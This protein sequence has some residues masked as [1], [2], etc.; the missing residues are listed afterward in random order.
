M[1]ITINNSKYELDVYN[2]LATGN[3][4]RI[5]VKR[6]INAKDLQVGDVVQFRYA[7]NEKVGEWASGTY[8]IKASAIGVR[9]IMWSAIRTWGTHAECFLGSRIAQYRIL[10]PDGTWREFI[11][12]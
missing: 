6:T 12:E 5:P 10:Q 3:L 4:K 8:F 1:K 9:E 2:A 11:E 7:E